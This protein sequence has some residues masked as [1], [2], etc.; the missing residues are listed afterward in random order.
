[1]DTLESIFTRRSI[2]KFTDAPVSDEDVNLLLRAAM[3]APSARNAQPWHFI[4]V[5]DQAMREGIA[6]INPHAQMALHAPVCVV[7]CANLAEE[8]IPGYWPQDCAAAV[9]N[10]L[11]AARAKNIGTVWTGV[12]PREERVQ[13]AKELFG[14]PDTVMPLAIIVIGH[15]AQPFSAQDRFDV[16][17][18]HYERW[19]R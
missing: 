14:L 12:Y 3:S 2:R 17:K 10:M 8:K 13:G 1:M 9:Q 11:L 16:Q 6:R 15:P 18:I 7:V 5:R 4:V 19:E